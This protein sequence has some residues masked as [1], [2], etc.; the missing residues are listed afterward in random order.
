MRLK[1]GKVVAERFAGGRRRNDNDI[2]TAA[3]QIKRSRL[4]RIEL[5]DAAALQRALE[6]R[7][8]SGGKLCELRLASRNIVI[9]RNGIALLEFSQKLGKRGWSG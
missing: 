2:L 3:R 8:R 9:A 6:L 5:L 7:G 4:M 1:D